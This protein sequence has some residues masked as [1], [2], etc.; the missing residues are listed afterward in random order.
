M[1]NL[2]DEVQKI[3]RKSFAAWLLAF[4]ILLTIGGLWNLLLLPI[5]YVVFVYCVTA[6]NSIP[7]PDCKKSYGV[8]LRGYYDKNISHIQI[9]SK[10]NSCGVDNTTKISTRFL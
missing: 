8:G 7:C 1:D 3:E 6:I 10:C 5:S 4:F 2:Y 9:P